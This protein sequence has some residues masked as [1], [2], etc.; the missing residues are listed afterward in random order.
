M[1]V[2]G[3]KPQIKGG[4]QTKYP[5]YNPVLDHDK[6]REFENLVEI[7]LASHVALYFQI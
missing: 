5:K 6:S 4:Q 7:F 1:I 2:T 3:R